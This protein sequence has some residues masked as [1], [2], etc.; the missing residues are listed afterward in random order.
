MVT[1]IGSW[2]EG[3]SSCFNEVVAT[4]PK[5]TTA[6]EASATKLRLARLSLA[7]LDMMD[8]SPSSVFPRPAPCGEMD[9]HTR[10]VPGRGRRYFASYELS[11]PQW[12]SQG[13]PREAS[14]G[15]NREI[16]RK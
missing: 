6:I 7:N 5:I 4:N 8:A 9:A 15:S 16:I 10:T 1:A 14:C 2:S 13:F 3:I 11:S 12:S